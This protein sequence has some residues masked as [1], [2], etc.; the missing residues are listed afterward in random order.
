MPNMFLLLHNSR[1]DKRETRRNKLMKTLLKGMLAAAALSFGAN[2]ATTFEIVPG[3]ESY[4]SVTA[5]QSNGFFGW[6]RG[7]VFEMADNFDL[8]SIGLYSDFTN[9]NLMWDIMEVNSITNV[10]KGT[11]LQSGNNIVSTDGLGWVDIDI[12]PLTL[13]A[14]HTYHVNFKYFMAANQVYT[15]YQ[16]DPTPYDDGI[17]LNIDGTL[18]YNVTVPTMPAIRLTGIGAITSGIPEPASWLLFILGFGV[19]G[20]VAQRRRNAALAL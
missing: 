5:E 20:S 12:S 16:P 6:G 18:G 10:V 1:N 14:G 15:Y 4:G 13:E 8:T 7:V 17:F 19:A 11:T 9:L 3:G 2:A